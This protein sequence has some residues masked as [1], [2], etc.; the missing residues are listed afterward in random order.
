[1]K[2]IK[3]FVLLYISI[4]ISTT[5][6]TA[7]D[8]LSDFILAAFEDI[9][10]QGYSDVQNYIVPKNYR[11]PLIDELEFRFSNDEFV[12]D[13]QEYAIRITPS[14][15]WYVRRNK[16]YFNATKKEVGLEQKL[17][18]KQNLYYR[19]LI[20]SSYLLDLKELNLEQER[21]DLIVKR[22]NIIGENAESS[23]FDSED[24]VDAKL[25]QIDK[26]YDV[27][28]HQS[29]LL[30]NKRTIS[31]LMRVEN[32]DW[33]DEQLVSVATI[34]SISNIIAQN[35]FK[36]AELNL[37]VQKL[38]VANKESRL[39]KADF[40]FG[41]VQAEYV[42]FKNRESNIGISFGFT[43]PI[44]QPNKD[45]IAENYIKEIEIENQIQSQE[46]QDSVQKVIQF[47]FLKDLLHHH[48][49]LEEQI[50]QID[51][52]NLINN[53][54]TNENNNP[55]TLLDIEEALIKLKLLKFD[56]HK[57]LIVQYI[58]FLNTFDMLSS[59]PLINYLS[60]E[61]TPIK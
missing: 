54:S 21:Y 10:T 11:I 32:I 17:I 16:A 14:N 5:A 57:R 31:S 30:H 51:I 56:S 26:L 48:Q 53:L 28:E 38:I 24:F 61:L 20:A 43:I 60:D 12:R 19:Y 18:Y 59:T 2:I 45:K 7:Q 22:V 4:L 27:Q 25:D 1:M 33:E 34:D 9:N 39:E 46:F 13:E 3:L 55:I 15:P 50:K 49:L 8:Q 6:S 42:P 35:A 37:L 52:P 58:E 41:Y 40:N 47:G 29:S 23:F 44:F 36:S